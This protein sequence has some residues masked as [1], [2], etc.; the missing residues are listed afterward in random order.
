MQRFRHRPVNKYS[1]FLVVCLIYNVADLH[2]HNVSGSRSMSWVGLGIRIHFQPEKFA[3]KITNFLHYFRCSSWFRSVSEVRPGS[4][5]VYTYCKNETLDPDQMVP[6]MT[7]YLM[8]P[9]PRN[10]KN[11]LLILFGPNR[12]NSLYWQHSQNINLCRGSYTP[13]PSPGGASSG[14]HYLNKQDKKMPIFGEIIE[15]EREKV[16]NLQ[17]FWEE[18]GVWV[19]KKC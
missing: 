1:G 14:L 16:S 4:G 11:S 18:K 10:I 9:E 7:I 12:Q 19:L 8:P 15:R 6:D 5:T 2:L 17:D 3:L 13:A